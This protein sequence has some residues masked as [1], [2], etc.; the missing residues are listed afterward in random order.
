MRWLIG[1]IAGALLVTSSWAAG[2]NQVESRR[3]LLSAYPELRI[4]AD[5][6]RIDRIYGPAFGF[7]A[8]A[9][10]AADE[11][12]QAH[13]DVLGVDYADLAGVGAQ[14]VMEGKFTAVYYEQRY[15][16]LPVDRSALTILVRHDVGNGIVL[17][18]PYVFDL[19]QVPAAPVVLSGAEAVALVAQR[20][21]TY[22]FTAPE[23]VVYPDR[24]GEDLIPVYAYRFEGDNLD[25]ENRE[26]YEFVVD[27]TTP[28]AYILRME[29][30]IYDVNI[31]G[32][33][34][35]FATPNDLPDRPDNPPVELALQDLRVRI[36]SSNVGTTNA[37]GDYTISNSGS[38]PVT[39]QTT[40]GN[41]GTSYAGRWV[42]I[43]DQQGAVLSYSQSV[44][45]PGPA[46]FVYNSTPSEFTTAQANGFYWTTQTHNYVRWAAP[47]YP[48]GIDAQLLCNVNLGQTCN[49]YYDYSSINFFKAGGGCPNT[50]YS[51]VIAHEYGHFVIH[52]GWSGAGGD[53]HEGMADVVAALLMDTD[54]L[55][56]G[57]Q[58]GFD[59]LRSGYNDVDC[60]CFGEPHYCGQVI[61]GAFWLLRDE[62]F[63]TE[64]VDY[65]YITANL[66]F[67]SILLHPSI[68]N[69]GITVDVLTL[70]DDDGDLTNGTPHY[71]EIASAFGAKNMKA[72]PLQV[73]RF[74]F[75]DGLPTYVAP[76]GSTTCRVEVYPDEMAPQHATGKLNWMFNGDFLP[77]PMEPIAA[78][79]YR[80]VFPTVDPGYCGDTLLF[81][82]SARTTDGYLS[83][84]PGNTAATAYTA[85]V[86]YWLN[87]VFADDFE[88]SLGW[89]VQNQSVSDGAW[90]QAVPVGNGGTRGD[91]PT[92]YDGSGS[93]FVTGNGTNQDLD[94]GPT[95]LLSPVLDL[96]GGAIYTIRYA[97]WFYNDD[98]DADR[99]VVEISNNGGSSWTTVEQV[100]NTNGWSE[101]SFRVDDYVTPTAQV[102][103]RFSA[104]DNPNNSLTEAA[105]DAVFVQGAGCEPVLGDMNCD[106]ELNNA[107]IPG[108]VLVMIDPEQYENENPYCP[109]TRADA[110]LDGELNNADIPVFV[111]MLLE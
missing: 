107:D 35:G 73:L 41:S 39:V 93:C 49:A 46:D 44:T 85:T 71:G 28:E 51:T 64:P 65:R 13:A 50:A 103:L 20:Y 57:F 62:L 92:D 60:P 45:P 43:N 96:S 74:E 21:P 2:G 47:S 79:V 63:V 40:F 23:P 30:R 7:A 22:T 36:T 48:S 5:G 95:R 37:T 84:Y 58:G 3:A 38:S 110:N 76:D 56:R 99:L 78:N 66:A 67:N 105:V 111:E 14:D 81:H 101:R 16:G 61:S 72:P 98:N 33:V 77:T 8:T 31:S 25:L 108:F 24:R 29:N 70:D 6:G 100:T 32:R 69:D 53:Y 15:A 17:V 4:L 54:C 83:V 89:T 1:V 11:F 104:S 106:G 90:V 34:T 27:A 88:G 97:R 86:A 102:Q 59:C 68:V 91:P 94:G 26:K 18:S 19:G 82:F 42:R 12:L 75:P 87:D 52:Q 109:K 10:Q 55:G 9:E 80:A